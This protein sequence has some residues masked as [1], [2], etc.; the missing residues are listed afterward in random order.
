MMT[1]DEFL[2]RVKD[3]AEIGS[4]FAAERACR[5]V[6]LTLKEALQS[7]DLEEEISEGL[8]PELKRVFENPAMEAVKIPEML[9]FTEDDIIEEGHEPEEIVIPVLEKLKNVKF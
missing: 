9:T 6:F 8:S 1:K 5:A 2:N 7:E 3:R 4:L